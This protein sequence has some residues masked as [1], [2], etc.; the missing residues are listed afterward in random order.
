L[1][2]AVQDALADGTITEGHARAIQVASSEPSRLQV[3]REVL[4][5]HLSVRET[6]ARARHANDQL[7]VAEGLDAAGTVP[8]DPD[9]QRLEDAF[10]QALGTRVRLVR[11][12]R[13][14]RL[15]IHFYSDEELQGIYEA[16]VRDER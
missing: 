2:R 1:P 5:E 12:R 3:L 10:R 6:E 7:A 4:A 11:G 16:I 9:T 15:V 14:G 13:G 8:A